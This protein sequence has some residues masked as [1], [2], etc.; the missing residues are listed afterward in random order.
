MFAESE[1]AT[2]AAP[3]TTKAPDST[4]QLA[5]VLRGRIFSRHEY[6]E[7]KRR[8]FMRPKTDFTHITPAISNAMFFKIPRELRDSI[9]Q[10]LWVD[11]RIWQRYKKK[12]YIVTYGDQGDLDSEENSTYAKVDSTVYWKLPFADESR[13]PGVMAADLQKDAS[14]RPSRV[15][16][17][18][19]VDLRVVGQERECR[20]HFSTHDTSSSTSATSLRRRYR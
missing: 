1:A 4:S 16:S 6:V 14:R 10:S 20:I 17:T 8:A 9:Y 5:R 13:Y 19:S 11:M 7:K 15:P 12:H 3:A 18:F 2:S